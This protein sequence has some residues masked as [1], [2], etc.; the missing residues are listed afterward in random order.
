MKPAPPTLFFT[1]PIMTGL[2]TPSRFFARPQLLPAPN[3]SP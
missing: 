3:P 2:A 1:P